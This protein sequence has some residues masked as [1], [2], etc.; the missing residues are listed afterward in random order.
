MLSFPSF[1]SSPFSDLLFDYL[2]GLTVCEYCY[3]Y[4]EDYTLDQLH[5]LCSEAHHGQ[6]AAEHDVE[7]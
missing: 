6:S 2:Q 3:E 7:Q 5:E 4:Q 1:Y